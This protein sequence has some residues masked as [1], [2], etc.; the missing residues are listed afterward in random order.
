MKRSLGLLCAA[1]LG[2]IPCASTGYAQPANTSYSVGVCDPKF[3]QRCIKPDALGR[4]TTIALL[5][6]SANTVELVIGST[7]GIATSGGTRMDVFR[8]DISVSIA[9]SIGFTNRQMLQANLPA[10]YYFAV[11][12]PAGTSCSIIGA[13]DQALG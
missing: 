8:N 6:P 13:T 9:L 5:T 12:R 7:N 11:R 1:L 4:I 3:P 2:T 10:N